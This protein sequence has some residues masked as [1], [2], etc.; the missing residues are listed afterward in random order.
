[1]KK[2]SSDRCVLCLKY[3]NNA[4]SDDEQTDEHVFPKSWYPDTTPNNLE[5]WQIPSC[6]TCN[7]KYSKIEED[8]LIRIGLCIPHNKIETIG[9]PEKALRSINPTY[10]KNEKDRKLRA[11]KKKKILREIENMKKLPNSGFLPNF[12]RMPEGQFQLRLGI[13]ADY[14]DKLAHKFIRGLTFK[15]DNLL[16]EDDYQINIGFLRDGDN[17]WFLE[18]INQFGKKYY[19]G[20]GINVGRAVA[21]NDPIASMYIIEIW[22]KLNIYGVV[23]KRD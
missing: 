11:A 5:K 7:N 2:K 23:T 1:M 9:I 15:I 10:A 4:N 6:Q 17:D 19:R 13:R 3:F 12:N 20:P 18:K 16:I 21:H 14:L 8:L 22:G